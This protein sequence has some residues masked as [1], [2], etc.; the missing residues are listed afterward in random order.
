VQ[1]GERL[2][3]LPGT[4]SAVVRLLEVE[5]ESVQWAAAGANATIYLAGIDPIHLSVGCVLCHPESPIPLVSTFIGQIIVFD[6]QVPLIAGS[7]IELFHQSRNVPASL[8]KLVAT[9]DRSTGEVIKKNPRVLAKNISARVEI[10]IR[11]TTLSGQS[12]IAGSIPLETSRMNKDMGRILIRRNG[13]T[14][15]AGIVMDI[16]D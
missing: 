9:L 2:A 1:V 10:A 13:E 16:V 15:A 8:S 7:S 14:V 6:I 3:V 12:G 5:E 11:T 4:E